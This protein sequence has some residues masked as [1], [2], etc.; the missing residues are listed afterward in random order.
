M[1][2]LQAGAA[3]GWCV[4]AQSPCVTSGALPDAGALLNRS[5]VAVERAGSDRSCVLLTAALLWS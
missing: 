1:D 5:A 3:L 2:A 4:G